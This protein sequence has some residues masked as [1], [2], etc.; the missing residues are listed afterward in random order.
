M[1]IIIMD[2]IRIFSY[3]ILVKSYSDREARRKL[4]LGSF[5][6]IVTASLSLLFLLLFFLFS[7]AMRSLMILYSATWKKGRRRGERRKRRCVVCVFFPG[8]HLPTYLTHSVVIRGRGG[9]PDEYTTAV[10]WH[11]RG[12]ERRRRDGMKYVRCRLFFSRP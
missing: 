10:G 11:G 3:S 2:F 8:S 9:A 1:V 5:P 4:A 7:D 12:E 6:S